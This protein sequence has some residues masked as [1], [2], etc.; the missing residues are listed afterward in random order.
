MT[1]NE[2]L[3]AIKSFFEDTSRSPE[4]TIEGL[5]AAIDDIQGYI[6]SLEVL[7]CA[8]EDVQAYVA[9]AETN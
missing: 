7:Q 3:E 8:L 9:S 6:E 4:A 2:L 1:E 5:K